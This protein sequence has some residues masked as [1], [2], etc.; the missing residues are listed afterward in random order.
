[1]KNH[2]KFIMFLLL[3]LVSVSVSSCE[4]EVVEPVMEDGN[5]GGVDDWVKHNP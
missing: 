5:I 3:I 2:I 1:M 4:E